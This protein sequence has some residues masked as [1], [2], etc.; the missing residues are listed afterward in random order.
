MSSYVGKERRC[1]DAKRYKEIV[2]FVSSL[3]LSIPDNYLI[4]YL[5]A[6]VSSVYTLVD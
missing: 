5:I 1:D 6:D 2:Q 3:Y 4:S